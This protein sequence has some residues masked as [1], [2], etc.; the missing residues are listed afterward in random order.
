MIY[1]VAPSPL[2]MNL[3]WAGTDDGLIHRTTNGGKSWTDVTPPA[4]SAWQKISILDAGHFDKNT[5]YAAVNTL[6]LDDLRPHIY[7]THDG[8]KSGQEIVHGIPRNRRKTLYV[9]IRSEGVC[10]SPEQNAPST[11]RL[12][13]AKTGSLCAST[14]RQ[15]RFATSLLRTTI[16]PWPPTAGAF[17]SS[18]TSRR[19]V[20]YE[21]PAQ[22]RSFQT[23]DGTAHPLEFQHGYAVA[24]G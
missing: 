14:C 3:I 17:G 12:T 6:R 18:I 1:T 8:G 23:A 10:F 20:S 19:C 7:R 21:G 4:I 22:D 15:L 5:A 13:T 16:S 2:D 11:Y 24:A 9:K